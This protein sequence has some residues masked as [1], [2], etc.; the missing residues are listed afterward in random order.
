MLRI[1]YS[2]VFLLN[3]LLSGAQI[4]HNVDLLD[5]WT[6][7]NVPVNN[8]GTKFNGCWGFEFNGEEYAVIGS[9]AGTHIFRITENDRL[10]EVDFVAGTSIHTT[11]S[12][13]IHREFKTYKNYLYGVCDAGN[14]TLQIM[15]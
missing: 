11:S 1:A 6:T 15:D 2:V 3:A 9:T 4:S 10:E 7:D 5:T 14:S 13:N 8:D 12:N